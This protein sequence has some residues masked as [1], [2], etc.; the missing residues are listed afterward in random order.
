M[1]IRISQVDFTTD[2]AH[3]TV[4][5]VGYVDYMFST[6]QPT[7]LDFLDKFPWWANLSFHDH[8]FLLFFVQHLFLKVHESIFFA[9]L[10]YVLFSLGTII[11]IYQWAKENFSD[12]VAFWSALFLSL[13]SLFLY[14]A[15]SG[16]MEAGVI[17][18][19]ALAMLLFYRFLKDQKYWPHLGIALGLCFLSKYNTFFIIPGWLAYILIKQRH[20]LKKKET[21]LA[22]LLT[23][24]VFSPVV[25]YNL[26]LYKTVGHF[27]YQFSRLFNMGSPWIAPNVEGITNL[28]W[29]MAYS[30]GKSVLFPY[31]FLSMAGLGCMLY[32]G[33]G[34]FIFINIIFLT[35]FFMVVGGE[36][37]YFNIYNIFLVVP[38]AYLIV[39][40]KNILKKNS[41][42]N[43]YKVFIFTFTGYLF[44]AAFNSH[45][46]IKPIWRESVGWLISADQSKNFGFYQ[47]NKYLD[48]L[49]KKNNI[50]DVRDGYSKFKVKKT[51]LEARY[52]SSPESLLKSPRYYEQA[53]IYDA[54]INWT[55]Q[56]WPFQR[57]RFYD[58]MPILD[59]NEVLKFSQEIT[60]GNSFIIKA[61]ENTLL[62]G[63]DIWSGFSNELEET[64]IEQ[65]MKP[66]DYIYRTDGEIAFKV[67]VLNANQI[68]K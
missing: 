62:R 38:I 32:R 5:S 37:H 50:Q 29:S 17:F 4:R 67:Y 59:T 30:L 35:A 33:R 23:L 60:V 3:Y 22:I 39:E 34:L 14:T 19:L 27:D 2:N 31:L 46:L 44:F 18:F 36:S 63:G 53:I 61:T 57:R 40:S 45:I 58:N 26:M 66:I 48:D 65:G 20:L 6:D 24:L 68:Q 41:Y 28:P 8:P 10:P 1:L 51:S 21:Y 56:L 52:G 43:I 25:I 9:K 16:F 55:A 11:L 42:R 49:I 54:N 12:G 64:F 15:R 47:L 7:P 13:N